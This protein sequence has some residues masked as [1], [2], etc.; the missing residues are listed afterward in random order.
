MNGNGEVYYD[1][2][3]MFTFFLL[4]G[5]Y[6]E[7]RATTRPQPEPARALHNLFALELSKKNQ[8][9]HLYEFL[10]KICR[11]ATMCECCPVILFLLIAVILNGKK[12]H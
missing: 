9:T 1:S 11:Q 4:T 6:L 12:Q 10:W 7:L 8:A 2:V 5:R 3:S